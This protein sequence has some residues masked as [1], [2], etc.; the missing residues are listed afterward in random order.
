MDTLEDRKKSE[1][2]KAAHRAEL[3]FK[4]EARRNKLFGLWAAEQMGHADPQA[5][6]VEVIAAAYGGSGQK[7][8]FGKVQ[9]DLQAAG[10]PIPE[11]EL[12][13][14]MNEFMALAE[15]QIQSEN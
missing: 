12:R 13:A 14:K 2:A 10:K 1:E 8:A 15:Q 3:R 5:Y 4:A 6:I 9:N 7:D 11:S